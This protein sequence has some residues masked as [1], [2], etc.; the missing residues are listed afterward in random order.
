GSGVVSCGVGRRGRGSDSTGLWL[1][2]SHAAA[3]PVGPLAIFTCRGCGPKKQKE[4]KGKEK[5]VIRSLARSLHPWTSGCLNRRGGTGSASAAR[6]AEKAKTSLR[7][8]GPDW[9]ARTSLRGAGSDWSQ[10][11]ALLIGWAQY[12]PRVL[13]DSPSFS[14][15][16]ARRGGEYVGAQHH[17]YPLSPIRPHPASSAVPGAHPPLSP[18][19]RVPGSASTPAAR[20]ARALTRCLPR[21][22]GSSAAAMAP[23]RNGMILKPHF[24]KDWQRRVATWFNQP[25]RKIRR[26]KA[27]QAK[28]RRIAPRPASGP[29][30]PVVRCPTVRYHTKVR[31]GRGFSLEELRVAGIHKKV[32]RTIGI[33]VDPRRRNKCTESLQANVQRL[34]EYRSK[35]ILF[36]RKPSAPKKGDSSAE[37]L[38]LATQLT[39]PVMPIRNVYKREKARVITDEEKNFKAFASLR[40]ARANARLFGIR[41]KRAKEAAEQDVEKKK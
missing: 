1:C 18:S 15:P 37:E 10:W 6:A 31:A 35:L 7:R 9:R 20:R 13:C 39:G 11:S 23:S 22:P 3:A 8:A 38:K 5:Q 26:R 40:M 41:A 4:K 12:H 29:L 32:A 36:P 28:A 21:A 2:C 24:H 30:R 19:G 17:R 33:S 25:A 27:R 16:C 14:L 34:K